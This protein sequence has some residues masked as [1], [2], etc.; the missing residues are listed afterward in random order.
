M[1]PGLVFAE[2]D[3][4]KAGFLQPPGGVYSAV[5]CGSGS[6]VTKEVSCA[7]LATSTLAGQCQLRRRTLAGIHGW[8]PADPVRHGSFLLSS[9]GPD[10]RCGGLVRQLRRVRE[11]R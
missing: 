1:K 2:P 5:P 6:P 7:L 3:K 8:A 11:L 10:R 4:T 9:S